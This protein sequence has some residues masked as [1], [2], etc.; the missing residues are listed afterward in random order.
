MALKTPIKIMK[1]FLFTLSILVCAAATCLAQTASGGSVPNASGSVPNATGTT[2]GKAKLGQ[3]PPSTMAGLPTC[4]SGNDGQLYRV[5]D[6]NRDVYSC[7]G[8]SGKWVSRNGGVFNVRD[9]GA[10]GDDSTDDTAAIQAAID[11][12]N[13]GTATNAVFIPEGTY[14]ITATI[15]YYGASSYG[16]AIRGAKGMTRGRTGAQLKWYGASGG[17]ALALVGANASEVENLQVIGNSLAKYPIAITT[18]NHVS[19]TLSGAITANASPQTVTLSNVTNIAIGTLIPIDAGASTTSAEIVEVTNVSGSTVTAIFTKNHANGAAVG[20]APGS[21][22]VKLNNVSSHSP[23]GTGNAGFLIGNK[24]ASFTPQVSEFECHNCYA[25]GSGTTSTGFLA[26]GSGNVKNL[27]FVD[28]GASDNSIAYDLFES[29][30]ALS[31]THAT[32]ANN[33]TYDFKIGT[34][35]VTLTA[36]EAEESSLTSFVFGT[37]GA[38]AGSLTMIECYLSGG[39]AAGR[40]VSY[41]GSITLIGN[42]FFNSTG[43][44]VA[45][46]YGIGIT[47]DSAPASITSIG[48]YYQ[49]ANAITDVFFDLSGDALAD[50][51][52]IGSYANLNEANLI[53]LNDYGG[54]SGAL[55]RFRPRITTGADFRIHRALFNGSLSLANVTANISGSVSLDLSTGNIRT[56]TLTGTVS[57]LT[58]TNIPTGP[59]TLVLIQDSTGSR[60]ITSWNSLFKFAGGTAP[61]LTTTAGAYDVLDFLCDGTACR[62]K[63]ATYDV[64]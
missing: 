23:A 1:R 64:K 54:I 14:K 37:T 48:N 52:T 62:L 58:A 43:T 17:I 5:T 21:S 16:I 35:N 2:S 61:T 34:A 25:Y 57:A 27:H 11:A 10:K 42:D 39:L 22:G 45:K 4:N 53:S 49:N 3:L 46:I 63:S 44:D 31:V 55:V 26:L 24:T 38:N 19:A 6:A 60:T 29:G 8:T 41:T 33:T 18:A 32:L 56:L 20:W 15:Q 9:F 13:S 51:L 50:F 28:G 30:S 47:T 36:I 12:A 59:L 7:Y 40:A